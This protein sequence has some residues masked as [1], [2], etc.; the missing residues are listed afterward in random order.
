M[1]LITAIA[2]QSFSIYRTRTGYSP[3]LRT[4]Y[5]N[6]CIGGITRKWRNLAIFLLTSSEKLP[7]QGVYNPCVFSGGFVALWDCGT[8]EPPGTFSNAPL[9]LPAQLSLSHMLCAGL[10][11]KPATKI[12]DGKWVIIVFQWEGNW[13]Y[14]NNFS[15]TPALSKRSKSRMES[16][17]PD[18]VGTAMKEASVQHHQQRT[19][20]SLSLF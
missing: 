15:W 9:D 16:S 7:A 5:P 13:N 6:N 14:I 20:A 4:S 11:W 10:V 1:V 17:P 3:G 18:A 12:L 2:C 8:A 19:T